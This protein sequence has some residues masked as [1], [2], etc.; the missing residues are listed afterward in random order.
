MAQPAGC[1]VT[2][3]T[4]HGRRLRGWSCG[5]LDATKPLLEAIEVTALSTLEDPRFRQYPVYLE[6]LP[7]LEL[8]ISII[9]PL[10]PVEHPLAFEPLART[11]S[12]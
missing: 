9:S 11:G 2:L 7:E 3:Q 10:R 5:R 12:T 4:L 1:F 6:E 8:E